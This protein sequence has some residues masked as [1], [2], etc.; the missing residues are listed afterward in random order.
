MYIFSFLKDLVTLKLCGP[1]EIGPK[2]A[3]LGLSWILHSPLLFALKMYI[4][5][6]NVRGCHPSGFFCVAGWGHAMVP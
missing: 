4:V 1:Q 5:L 6:V 3:S 2:E